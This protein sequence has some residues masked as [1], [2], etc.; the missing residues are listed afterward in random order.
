MNQLSFLI[1]FITTFV[2]I[3]VVVFL[4]IRRMKRKIGL[5]HANSNMIKLPYSPQAET[6]VKNI[7]DNVGFPIAI[8]L[9]V[10]HIGKTPDIY[11]STEKKYLR[12]LIKLADKNTLNGY[13]LQEDYL[14]FHQSGVYEILIG[15]IT[16][17][18]ARNIDLGA[19]DFSEV[20]EIGEGASARMLFVPGK[21]VKM[22]LL[23]SAPSQFQLREIVSAVTS[24]FGGISFHVPK[25][26]DE[27]VAEFNSPDFL[28]KA[29]K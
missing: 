20:N 7:L 8:D 18:E 14:V 2:I 21:N 19:I 12:S 29:A 27:A 4:A 5:S 25:S 6:A 16:K 28:S 23:C 24:S 9:V 13:E 26:R 15:E 22:F 1:I 11:I 3:A 10:E 17:D